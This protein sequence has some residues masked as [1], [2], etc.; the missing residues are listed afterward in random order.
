M[1]S[2]AESDDAWATVADA[3]DS[4]LRGDRSLGDVA[5]LLASEHHRTGW[6]FNLSGGGAG[7]P[8]FER[9]AE[10]LAEYDR[11][12]EHKLESDG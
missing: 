7:S 5:K 9:L 11:L 3:V 6:N 1:S 8:Y 4:F 10:L 2:E 12:V